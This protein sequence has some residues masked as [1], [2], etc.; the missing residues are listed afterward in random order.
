MEN[1]VRPWVSCSFWDYFPWI[2]YERERERVREI[3]WLCFMAYQSF[4]VILCQTLCTRIYIYIYI[5]DL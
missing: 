4:W 1:S 3:G 2:K 5:Y